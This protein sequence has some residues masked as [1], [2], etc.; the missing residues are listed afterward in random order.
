M[1]DP[2]RA[3]RE[4][5]AKACIERRADYYGGCVGD[6][7]GHDDGGACDDT[8]CPCMD[9]ARIDASAAISAF[10]RTP[11]LSDALHAL[12][13]R[14]ENVGRPWTEVL[15]EAVERGDA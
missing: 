9:G 15:A 10:L 3:A 12:M 6:P 8:H 13:Q 14:P 11:G 4:A 1:S 5:A 7:L 2:I